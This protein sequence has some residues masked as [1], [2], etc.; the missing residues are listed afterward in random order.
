MD[1]GAGRPQRQAGRLRRDLV[2]LQAL[3][4]RKEG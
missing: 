1:R 2:H 3:T 4:Q